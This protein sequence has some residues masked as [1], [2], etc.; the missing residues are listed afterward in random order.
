MK[1]ESIDENDFEEQIY[2]MK[3]Y[4]DDHNKRHNSKHG[5]IDKVIS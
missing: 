3:E 1:D 2:Q 5:D 4:I